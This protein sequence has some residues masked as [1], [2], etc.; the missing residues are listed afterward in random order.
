M[1]WNRIACNKYSRRVH[2]GQDLLFFRVPEAMAFLNF[3]SGCTNK[4]EAK[5]VMG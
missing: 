2:Q 5:R 4:H 3:Y 1:I